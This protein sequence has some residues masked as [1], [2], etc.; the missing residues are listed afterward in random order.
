MFCT[1]SVQ[2]TGHPSYHGLLDVGRHLGALLG[3]LLAL[4]D[5]HIVVLAV[6][7]RPCMVEQGTTDGWLGLSGEVGLLL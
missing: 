1:R 7:H 6:G 2:H 5:V 3:R 4:V